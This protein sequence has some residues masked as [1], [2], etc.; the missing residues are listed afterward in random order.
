MVTEVAF[1][2]TKP[3]K[4]ENELKMLVFSLFLCFFG[5]FSVQ[6]LYV[7]G[8]IWGQNWGQLR[9]SSWRIVRNQS[10]RV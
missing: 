5:L 1:L 9:V 8:Q 7:W 6:F 4:A 2:S 3:I 10:G